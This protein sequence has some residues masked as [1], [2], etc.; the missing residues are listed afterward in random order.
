[1]AT[2]DK[3]NSPPAAD[4]SIEEVA[5]QLATENTA[6]KARIKELEAVQQQKAEDEKVIGEKMARG[7][8]RQQAIT[9]IERQRKFD[10]DKAAE[11]AKAEKLK[12]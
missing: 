5:A 7:L 1:M 3:K 12:S 2:A 4:A 9:V 10:A 8:S 11:K 6:L